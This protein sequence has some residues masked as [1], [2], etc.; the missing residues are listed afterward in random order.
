[1]GLGHLVHFLTIT[2]GLVSPSNKSHLPVLRVSYIGDLAFIIAVKVYFISGIAVFSSHL[3]L[4][5]DFETKRQS[6]H[7]PGRLTVLLIRKVAGSTKPL[8]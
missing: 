4:K 3:L 1:M 2:S 7:L 5:V 8:I 6:G